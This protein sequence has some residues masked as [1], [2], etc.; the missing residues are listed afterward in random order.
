MNLY[1]KIKLKIFS[2][3]DEKYC[4]D[5]KSCLKLSFKFGLKNKDFSP[6]R[7]Y[8][9]AGKKFF[10]KGIDYLEGYGMCEYER[11]CKSCG[12]LNGYWSYG[13]WMPY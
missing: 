7:C 8:K 2:F 9:C 10:D 3:L 11:R 4:N 1:W 5:I 13:H 12:A 6:K